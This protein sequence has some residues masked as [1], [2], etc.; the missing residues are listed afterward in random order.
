MTR[1]ALALL[2]I[3][4]VGLLK[5]RRRPVHQTDYSGPSTTGT[6]VE[7]SVLSTGTDKLDRIDITAIVDAWAP[8][9]VLRSNGQAGHR[10]PN[11]AAY[12]YNARTGVITSYN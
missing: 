12:L 2:V 8:S 6:V 4:G 3:V 7:S 11:S 1:V 10:R 9:T 5:R